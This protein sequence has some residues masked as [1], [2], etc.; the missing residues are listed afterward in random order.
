MVQASR[1][2]PPHFYG[3]KDGTSP[4]VPSAPRA[5][6]FYAVPKGRE[7][8]GLTAVCASRGTPLI[9]P[10]TIRRKAISLSIMTS[11]SSVQKR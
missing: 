2:K 3:T 8:S 11:V 4:E 1:R 10:T 6:G 5:V 7:A 9:G